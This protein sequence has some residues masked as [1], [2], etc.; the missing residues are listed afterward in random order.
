MREFFIAFFV[1][2]N[3]FVWIIF[4]Y[5]ISKQLKL[6]KNKTFKRVILIIQILFTLLSLYGVYKVFE[7][8][9]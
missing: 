8:F 6:K 9:E 2:L 7:I 4:P 5:I 3:L 1:I